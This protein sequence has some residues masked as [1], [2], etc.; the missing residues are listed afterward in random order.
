MCR[1]SH[2][3]F[4]HIG[5]RFA[6]VMARAAQCDEVG[7]CVRL[8]DRPRYNVVNVKPLADSSKRG[9]RLSA[10]FARPAVAHPS[11]LRGCRPIGTPAVMLGRSALPLRAVRSR[12]CAVARSNITGVAAKLPVFA[13]E[14]RECLAARGALSAGTL[15]PVPSVCVVAGHGA[16]NCAIRPISGHAECFATTSASLGN[17]C[18]S[19]TR[20]SLN[21]AIPRRA[22]IR[23]RAITP[24]ILAVPVAVKGFSALRAGVV[25]GLCHGEKI[26]RTRCNIKNFAI[27]CKRV[28]EAARQ[29]DLFIAAPP[30]KPKQEPLL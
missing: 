1:A 4:D 30:P 27:A 19:A 22:A 16:K 24:A 10:S 9:F 23:P 12:K 28:D 29:D 3:P 18:G 6:S 21:T 5:A 7:D 20:A 17:P 8:T 25:N 13:S 14:M 15:N 26:T 2:Q 11:S